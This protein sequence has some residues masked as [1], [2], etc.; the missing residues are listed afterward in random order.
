MSEPTAPL[1]IIGDAQKQDVAASKGP[2]DIMDGIYRAK[3]YVKDEEKD[4]LIHPRHMAFDQPW[5]W[6]ADQWRKARGHRDPESLDRVFLGTLAG[7]NLM[8]DECYVGDCNGVETKQVTPSEYVE[9][10]LR[11]RGAYGQC[12]TLR[13][14]GGEP[15]LHQRWV[16]NV[17]NCTPPWFRHL[18]KVVIWVDTNLTIY[19]TENLRDTLVN[20]RENAAICGCL[21]PNRQYVTGETVSLDTQLD[22]VRTIIDAGIN[23][24]LYWPAWDKEPNGNLF[25]DTLLELKTIDEY[26]PLR[27]TVTETKKYEASPRMEHIPYGDL[28]V[29][30]KTRRNVHHDFLLDNYHPDLIHMPSHLTLSL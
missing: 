30:F 5:Q 14:S 12:S 4:A 26:L 13:V 15:F 19:P 25:W 11:Y 7:C 2:T 8:C 23:L 9:A 24:F 3:Q 22:I 21:K 28:N 1:V 16:E 6:A 20:F 29:F 27:L 10:Y 18:Q 17:V